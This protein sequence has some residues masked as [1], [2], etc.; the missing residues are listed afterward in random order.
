MKWVFWVAASLIA[1]YVRG[2]YR[3]V[4]VAIRI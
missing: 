3:V 1:L 4:V 2:I